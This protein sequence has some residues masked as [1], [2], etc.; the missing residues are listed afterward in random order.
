MRVAIVSPQVEVS[1]GIKQLILLARALAAS[2]STVDFVTPDAS[3]AAHFGFPVAAI[4]PDMA[5]ARAPYDVSIM[6]WF[7]TC[8]LA[9]QLAPHVI[10]FC[11]GYEGLLPHLREET[12]AIEEVYAKPIVTLAVSPHLAGLLEERFRRVC[13]VLSPFLDDYFR[14]RARI[15]PHR[16]PKIIV[17]GIYESIIKRVPAALEAVD[18]L[19]RVMPASLCRISAWPRCAAEPAADEYHSGIAAPDVA[20]LTA[21]ADLTLF[22]SDAAEGF[23]LPVLESL[24]AGIP[25]VAARIPSLAVFEQTGVIDVC[26]SAEPGLLAAAMARLL[27]PAAWRRARS[28]ARAFTALWR[29][30]QSRRAA[31]QFQRAVALS[32]RV[33][34]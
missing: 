17:H 21:G 8:G 3:R 27:E 31:L 16:P 5:L 10:H 33:A 13:V 22:T 1:G 28:R 20:A 26:A 7:T 29:R 9:E 34:A 24:A 30:D 19:R 15:A 12:G 32:V 14:P 23:G 2:G 11:Q 6:S 25:V 18:Q 4:S